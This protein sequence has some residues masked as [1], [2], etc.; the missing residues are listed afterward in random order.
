MNISLQT[1]SK[2]EKKKYSKKIQHF[3][4]ISTLH[5]SNKRS[6]PQYKHQ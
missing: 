2:E 6:Y 3:I 4:L 5:E 1:C